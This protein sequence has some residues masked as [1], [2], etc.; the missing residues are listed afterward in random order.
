MEEIEVKFLDI[1]AADTERK[2]KK[3]GA[4]KKYDRVFKD[5]VFDYPGWPLDAD[6][7]WLRLRDK[8][9][10]ITLSF[11]QRFGKSEAGDAGMEEVEIIVSDFEET[12]VLLMK[13]GMEVKFDEEKRRVHYEIDDVEVDIDT[14]PLIPSYMEIEGKNWEGVK[15]TAEAL[16]LKWE[17]RKQLGAMQVFEMYGVH[18]KDYRILTFGEQVKR[19]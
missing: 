17:Q 11:K 5:R 2:L 13:I 12:S 9:D 7:S 16:D 1:K 14:W 15:K 19:F 18:E 4:V 8:G 3:L 10:K 6:K